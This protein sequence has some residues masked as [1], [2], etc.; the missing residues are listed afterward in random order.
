MSD[1]EAYIRKRRPLFWSVSE[2]KL[3][4]ISDELLV[5]SILNY[6]TLDDV[7]ALFLLLGLEHVAEVFFQSERRARHN[8]F[9]ETA[10]FFRIYFKRHAPQYSSSFSAN[11]S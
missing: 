7:R 9:P 4:E 8:Y 5:E 10:N 6:G 1:R 11:Q 3:G 2:D